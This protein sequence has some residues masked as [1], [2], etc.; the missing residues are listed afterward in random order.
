MIILDT[1]ILS[2]VMQEKGDRMILKWL[3]SQ[4]WETI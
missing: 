3:N 4:A 1:N 2:A